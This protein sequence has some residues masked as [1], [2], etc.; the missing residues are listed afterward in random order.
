MSLYDSRI[1]SKDYDQMIVDSRDRARRKA[2]EV[3]EPTVKRFLV[4]D[5]GGWLPIITEI[6]EL[7]TTGQLKRT[8][9]GPAGKYIN[10]N[11]DRSYRHSLKTAN[12]ETIRR[13]RNH[14]KGKR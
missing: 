8:V 1:A 9:K 14:R 11:Q 13:A 4:T 10:R 2:L 6:V 7:P 12:V 3:E 5:V